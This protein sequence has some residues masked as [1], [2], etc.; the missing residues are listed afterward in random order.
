MSFISEHIFPLEKGRTFQ[1]GITTNRECKRIEKEILK[2]GGIHE[3]K[4]DLVTFPHA[5]TI[6]TN[7][8]IDVHSVEEAA[9]KAGF[10]LVSRGFW[11]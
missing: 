9:K 10:H 7:K 3:I 6:I 4:F 2:V 1:V 11:V 5:I 8:M